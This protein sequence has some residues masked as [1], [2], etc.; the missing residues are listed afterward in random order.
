MGADYRI[1]GAF[2]YAPGGAARAANKLVEALNADAQGDE[3][4]WDRCG[5]TSRVELADWVA[6]LE[7]VAKTAVGGKVEV[8]DLGLDIALR[9]RPKRKPVEVKPWKPSAPLLHVGRVISMAVHES[10]L[11]L[12]GAAKGLRW[13]EVSIWDRHTTSRLACGGEGATVH[14]MAF[15]PDGGT[16]ALGR[17]NGRVTLWRWQDDV[18]QDVV[19][20]GART[21][22][23]G[24]AWSLDGAR[25]L[26]T[27]TGAR[28]VD[29]QTAKVVAKHDGKASS[30]AWLGDRVVVAEFA[31]KRGPRLSLLDQDLQQVRSIKVSSPSR[32]EV[33]GRPDGGA[34]LLTTSHSCE[35]LTPNLRRRA[36]SQGGSR[37]SACGVTGRFALRSRDELVVFAES[38]RRM[39]LDVA[40]LSYALAGD[41]V[42]VAE[43]ARAVATPL[44]EPTAATPAAEDGV[45]AVVEVA[46]R[47]VNADTER[48][49]ESPGAEPVDPWRVF[50]RSQCP[51]WMSSGPP[52]D[53]AAFGAWLAALPTR[54]DGR[55][56][57]GTEWTWNETASSRDGA[58]FEGDHIVW[59]T[60]MLRTNQGGGAASESVVAFLAGGPERHRG[61]PAEFLVEMVVTAWRRAP[62]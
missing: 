30:A 47:P 49:E 46:E 4:R 43:G 55:V 50:V 45:S 59:W 15:S 56:G 6:N 25:L 60:E 29:R 9:L 19:V 2:H 33:V 41:L 48:V 13:A 34:V 52:D 57:V 20:G 27:T 61:V 12:A 5:S 23:W 44:P 11:A 31:A 17:G 28:M 42:Y 40:V 1:V 54:F 32:W 7:T 37:A 3:L 16:L 53:D 58:H 62:S 18:M 38:T 39:P 14:A 36:L 22:V 26:V 21:T 10:M 24:L 51:A 8:M 35:V